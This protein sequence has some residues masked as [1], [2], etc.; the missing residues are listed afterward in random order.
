MDYTI[1]KETTFCGF[2]KRHKDDISYYNIGDFAYDE[3]GNLC[4]PANKDE[5][6]FGK[7]IDD[8]IKEHWI[9]DIRETIWRK[10]KKKKDKLIRDYIKGVEANSKL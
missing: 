1:G 5:Y 3:D 8:A 6:L 9:R 2:F 10:V 4:E 7:V